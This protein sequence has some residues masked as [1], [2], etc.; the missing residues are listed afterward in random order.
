MKA[1]WSIIAAIV[2]QPRVAD[3]LIKRA[4]RTPYSHI[5]SADGADVY[6]YRF[7]LFNPYSEDQGK[8]TGAGSE[9]DN[10]RWTWLPSIRIHHIMREDQ[11]RDLHD[12][13]WNARTIVLRGGYSEE[14]PG[15]LSKLQP[16]EYRES[17]KHEA[18][19]TGRLLYGEYH[20]I[21]SVS[22]GGV[23]TL[24]FTWKYRG[25]WG[26]NV[27]G[28]K[29]PWRVYLGHDN[30][31]GTTISAEQAVIN[32]AQEWCADRVIRDWG[33][34]ELMKAV[35]TLNGDW[36][37]CDGCDHECDE[38]CMPA[39]VAEYHRSVDYQVAQL[40]HD[41]KLAR[42]VGYEPPAGWTPAYVRPRRVIPITSEANAGAT[43]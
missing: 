26:F 21:T 18:G 32:A 35:T 8:K 7:W 29:I 34:A 23:W 43:Q 27:N 38:P 4:Q 28:K 12:H 40:V 6:M 13:P 3:A 30:E 11:D 10:R 41:G 39:T 15:E 17:F 31:P 16:F 24:F 2:S 37:G 19:Y 36:P 42:Y 25:T 1:L 20:R 9:K 14:R 33:D 22:A 5:T